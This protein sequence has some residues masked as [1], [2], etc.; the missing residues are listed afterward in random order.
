ML[1]IRNGGL[2]DLL[3]LTPLIRELNNRLVKVTLATQPRYFDLFDPNTVELVDSEP[4][5]IR[6]DTG[7]YDAVVDLNGKAEKAELLK[8]DTRHRAQ[9]FADEALVDLEGDYTIDIKHDLI[10]DV[11]H[12]YIVY[13]WSSSADNRN[14]TYDKHISILKRLSEHYVIFVI[15]ENRIE[16]P[17]LQ[18][19]NSTGTTSLSELIDLVNNAGL[20]VSPDTGIFHIA[21]A[22][23][24]PTITYFGAFPLNRRNSGKALTVDMGTNK[25]DVKP[26]LEYNCPL[27]NEKV[28]IAPCIDFWLEDLLQQ[29]Y[30]ILPI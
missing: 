24:K 3:M 26:C 22:L 9:I 11:D 10:G 8:S 17:G 1:L 13:V 15:G 6:M 4:Y 18:V 14:L 5:P 2:G 28:K 7:V 30:Q 12:S 23:N 19:N 16:L 29:V 27:M 21:R 20:I 25:C